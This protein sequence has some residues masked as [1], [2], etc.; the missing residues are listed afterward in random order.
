MI[1][2]GLILNFTAKPSISYLKA[3]DILIFGRSRNTNSKDILHEIINDEYGY[4]VALATNNIIL[5]EGYLRDISEMHEYTQKIIDKA[6]L[7]DPFI[8]IKKNPYRKTTE[9]LYKVDYR[10]LNIIHNKARMMY[11]KIA[12]KLNISAKT[13]KKRIKNMFDEN[14]VEFS[15]NFAPQLEGMI[16]SNFQI[17]INQESDS[18]FEYDE[19]IKKYDNYILY[20]QQFSNQPKKIMLTALVKSNIE[21]SELYSKLQQHN[22]AEIEQFIIFFGE[23]SETWRDRLFQQK[24]NDL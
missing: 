24:L 21:L 5:V 19:I 20:I 4:F 9:E 3:I 7:I 10:I 6:E 16:V 2:T 23:F 15:I 18:N 22:F 13:V 14:L 1:D 12:E 11:N 8:A 17:Q